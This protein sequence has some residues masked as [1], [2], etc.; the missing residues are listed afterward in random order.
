[1]G[2]EPFGN[3]M[4]YLRAALS[5][6]SSSARASTGFPAMAL[7]FFCELEMDDSIGTKPADVPTVVVPAVT[8]VVVVEVEVTDVVMVSLSVSVNELVTVVVKVEVD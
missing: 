1:M 8:V 4:W 2:F 5:A 3:V 7:R 6:R